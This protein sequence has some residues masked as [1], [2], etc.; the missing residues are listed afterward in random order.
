MHL[1]RTSKGGAQHGI[2]T[3]AAKRQNRS[4]PAQSRA[5]ISF[6]LLFTDILRRRYKIPS[7]AA[8]AAHRAP[9]ALN[10]MPEPTRCAT[11]IEVRYVETDQMG[12]VHHANYIAWLE[13]ARTHLCALSGFRYADIEALGYLLMV[14]GVDLKY[15]RPARYGDTVQVICWGER[16]ASRGVRFAYEVRRGDDL[17]A[18]G[19]TE[20]VWIEAASGR[21]C[22][23]PEQVRAPFERLAG[24]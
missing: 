18:T 7:P 8:V 24:V 23:L 2:K 6:Q 4:N 17:L 3:R 13:L 19:H 21:P 5:G 10:I 15:R 22:R 11:D 9:G 14:T 1:M 12:V 16:L 20:H